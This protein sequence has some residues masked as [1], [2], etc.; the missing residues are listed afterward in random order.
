MKIAATY[1]RALF[2]LIEHSEGGSKK[3]ATYLGNLDGVLKRRGHQKLLPRIFA[4]YQKLQLA[5]QRSEKQQE[6]TEE[7]ERTRTLLELYRKLTKTA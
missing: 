1:A 4:E 7:S 2:D 6:V 3:A 5:K